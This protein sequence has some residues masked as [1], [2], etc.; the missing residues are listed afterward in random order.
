VQSKRAAEG[1]ARHR[2]GSLPLHSLPSHG[3]NAARGGWALA[4][5][6]SRAAIMV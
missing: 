5:E 2:A 3:L 1:D 4:R 6:N